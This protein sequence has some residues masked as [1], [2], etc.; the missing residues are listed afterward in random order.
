M[1]NIPNITLF[2]D[3]SGHGDG[4]YE[5][6]HNFG[7]HPEPLEPLADP[8]SPND[9]NDGGSW[10]AQDAK[11]DI[12]QLCDENDLKDDESDSKATSCMPEL[13]L[14]ELNCPPLPENKPT[15]NARLAA[16]AGDNH[17]RDYNAPNNDLPIGTVSKVVCSELSPIRR[18]QSNSTMELDSSKATVCNIPINFGD[19]SQAQSKAG[20]ADSTITLESRFRMSMAKLESEVPRQTEID[21]IDVDMK[22]LLP[23]HRERS[24][25]LREMHHN[26]EQNNCIQG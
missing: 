21:K 20:P 19:V 18:R 14:S 8:W 23:H 9:P 4:H 13:G 15:E 5:V 24:R 2:Q 16:E 6:D 3:D 11:L 7:S 26:K 12:S 10:E 25:R 1:G 17:P 22:N